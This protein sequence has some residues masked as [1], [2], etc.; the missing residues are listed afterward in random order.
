M[1]EVEPVFEDYA[2][3]TKYAVKIEPSKVKKK[4]GLEEE[5]DPEKDLKEDPEEEEE[6]GEPSK[7]NE[8]LDPDSN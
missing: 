1:Q 2:T 5:K 6:E 3:K 8:A 4:R 7:A